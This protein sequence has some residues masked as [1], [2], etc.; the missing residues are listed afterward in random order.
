MDTK[1]ANDV[2]KSEFELAFLLERFEERY[3][4]LRNEATGEIRWPIRQFPDTVK[5][6]DQVKLKLATAKEDEAEKYRLQ[7]RLLEELIN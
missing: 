7:R 4:V 5:V 3:A 1:P 6:G 2:N